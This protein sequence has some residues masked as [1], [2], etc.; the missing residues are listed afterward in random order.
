[1]ATL[2]V[3]GSRGIGRA[4][5]A[6]MAAP[7]ET[8]FINFLNAEGEAMVTARQ[9]EQEGGT[10]VLL[11]GDVS[12]PQGAT[13]LLATVA[14]QCDRLDNLIHCA[15]HTVPGPLL[16]TDPDLFRRAVD[17]NAM[18]LLYV[19]QAARPL[20]GPGSS[21]VFLSSRGS[22][23][24]LNDYASVGAPKAMA[25]AMVRYVAVELARIGARANVVSPTAQD[26]AAFRAIFPNDHEERLAAAAR[27]N[28]SGRAVNFDDIVE[29][30]KF[31]CSPAA[32]MIQGQVIII[33]GGSSL[34]G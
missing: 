22:R 3:G 30:V 6:G 2:V 13:D 23:I 29:T 5:A 32:A 10:A 19:L 31:L 25:E 34:V 15:V 17:V 1:M 9:V 33:D 26:T 28:P 14:Q 12:T 24:A 18:S 7:Q 4:L 16:S 11:R 27:T 21:V 20:L 8:V